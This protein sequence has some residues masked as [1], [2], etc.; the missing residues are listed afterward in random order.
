MAGATGNIYTGLLEF[1]EMVFVLHVLRSGD[2]F[3]DVGANIGAYTIL[4]AKNTGANVIAI[5]PV[6]TTFHHLKCNVFLN[7]VSHLVN[8]CQAGVG[9]ESSRRNFT[10]SRDSVNHVIVD[11][12]K[13]S[14]TDFIEIQ[15]TTLDEL[16]SNNDPVIMKI[17]IEGFEWPALMGA[18]KMLRSGSLKGIIIELNGSGMRY[19]YDDGEIHKKLL[20]HS[21]LPYN[22]DPFKRELNLQKTYGKH[23]TLYIRDLDWVK[24][25]IQNAR[26]FTIFEQQL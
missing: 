13:S 23:N 1:D 3:A 17:D 4:A 11:S 19:G 10:S 20:S 26:E 5:E 15:V 2:R 8:L 9:N 24:R 21:F 16:C 12:E 18:E 25:R 7:D 22:Y 14:V 6:P